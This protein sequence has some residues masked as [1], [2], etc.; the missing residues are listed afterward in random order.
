[1]VV[2]EGDTLAVEK[3]FTSEDMINIL[4]ENNKNLLAITTDFKTISGKLAAGEGTIGKFLHDSTVY[5]NV[6]RATA[7]L[8]SAAVKADQLIGS[9]A[10]FSSGLNKKGTLANELTSDTIVFNSVKSSVLKLQQMADT[11]KLLVTNLK[12]AGNN[13]H[14][15]IGVL[16]YDEEAG[17]ALKKTIKNLESGSLK[18][19]A[20]LEAAQHTFL[21]R[22][23]FRKQAKAAKS[24]LPAK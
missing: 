18:L 19:D 11:A 20:D 16:L 5:L 10:T 3:T 1:M 2:Q 9:L 4:Q 6:R 7:S 17:A 23:F 13:P 8:Q 14:S 12:N 15:S 22:G 21:L 24:D